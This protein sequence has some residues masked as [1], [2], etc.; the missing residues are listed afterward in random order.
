MPLLGC[1]PYKYRCVCNINID[2]LIAHSVLIFLHRDKEP[3]HFSK[4]DFPPGNATSL[5]SQLQLQKKR[6]QI[7]SFKK[8]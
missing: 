2:P 3:T 5:Q 6:F 4:E 8:K 7:K 1:A